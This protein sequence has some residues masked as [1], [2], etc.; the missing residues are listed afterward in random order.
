MWR[1]LTIF[2]LMLILLSCSSTIE[3]LVPEYEFYIQNY[4]ND[5]IETS[6]SHFKWE[7]IVTNMDDTISSTHLVA[8]DQTVCLCSYYNPSEDTN[9]VQYS[10]SNLLISLFIKS[11]KGDTLY[12]ESPIN[13]N[14]WML[15]DPDNLY[16]IKYFFVYNK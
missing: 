7:Y 6:I 3:P 14:M 16:K 9:G 4:S 10:P 13:D 1:K 2:A 12:K 8:P 11:Q 15:Y 5:T